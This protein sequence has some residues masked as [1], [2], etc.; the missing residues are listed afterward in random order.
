MLNYK[1]WQCVCCLRYSQCGNL[2]QILV[3]EILPLWSHGGYCH[4]VGRFQ[5]KRKYMK[6]L[7]AESELDYDFYG[8]K[9]T[10]NLSYKYGYKCL[11]RNTQTFQQ[12]Q[13]NLHFTEQK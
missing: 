3:A 1:I 11:R 5:T 13:T 7:G 4:H 6:S 2:Y 10:Q 12:C 9:W 8:C